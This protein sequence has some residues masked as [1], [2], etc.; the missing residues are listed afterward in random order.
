[1][2]KINKTPDFDDLIVNLDLQKFIKFLDKQCKYKFTIS[3]LPWMHKKFPDI[4]HDLVSSS[5]SKNMSY[6]NYMIIISILPYTRLRDAP[7]SPGF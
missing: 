3:P 7:G 4:F 6:E 1:M 5:V 2:K